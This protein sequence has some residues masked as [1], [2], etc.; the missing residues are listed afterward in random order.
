VALFHF[1]FYVHDGF[2]NRK[3]RALVDLCAH[4]TPPLPWPPPRGGGWGGRGGVRPLHTAP[5]LT[6]PPLLFLNIKKL[7][8]IN[9]KK[10]ARDITNDW[11]PIPKDW[12]HSEHNKNF[13]EQSGSKHN[14]Q[15]NC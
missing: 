9:V 6:P 15:D 1:L 14:K 10:N 3:V 8:P 4:S 7:T 12:K 2:P 11:K 5:S 13:I